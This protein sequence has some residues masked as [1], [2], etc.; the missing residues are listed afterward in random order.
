MKIVQIEY[1]IDRGDF[2][3]SA[4]WA[5]TLSDIKKAISKVVWPPGNDRF[6]VNPSRGKGRGEGN[7]VTP[8]KDTC[9]AALNSY[10]WETDER[11]NSYRFDAIKRLN[12]GIYFGLEWETGNI[13]STHRSINRIL[14]A[15][16]KDSLVGGAIILPTRELYRYLT[17]RVGNFEELRPYFPI[18]KSCVWVNGIL[19]VIA[20]EH[21]ATDES[22]PRIGKGTDG[23]AMI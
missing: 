12:N 19:V 4:E 14:L 15:H 2:R 13:S 9:I 11:R 16:E 7:G 20:I 3:S 22:V 5:S 6:V 23:R 21:D 1:V 18:W 10:G 17:D 8:I